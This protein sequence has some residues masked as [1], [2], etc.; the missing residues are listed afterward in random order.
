MIVCMYLCMYVC[1]YVRMYVCMY[2]CV[3]ACMNV[4]MYFYKHMYTCTCLPMSGCLFLVLLDGLSSKP[5][6]L[7]CDDKH[8]H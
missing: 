7:S 4:Y 5:E 8:R 2:V 1:F 3:Y 6:V